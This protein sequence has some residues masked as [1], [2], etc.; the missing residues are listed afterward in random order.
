MIKLYK[1]AGSFNADE[2]R[3]FREDGKEL[4]GITGMLKQMLFKD[5]YKGVS[6]EVLQNAAERGHMIHSR[7]ELYDISGLGDDMP[8]VT[9]YARLR[10]MY[11]LEHI[12]SEYLVSDDENY[13][14]AIDKVYHQ[15][16]TPVDE[17]VL[18]D[19]KTTYNFNRDYVSWQLSVYAYFFEMMN[20]HLKVGRLIGIWIRNDKNRGLI[21]KIID[22]ERK[23]A[24]IVRELIRCAVEGREFTIERIPSF[25]SDNLDRLIWINDTISALS[26][27]KD[28]I[29]KDIL[30]KMQAKN[31]DKIDAGVVLFTKKAGST[32]TTF[33]SKAFKA[34]H[35]D[36]YEQYS[37]TSVGS[38]TLQVKFRDQ[39]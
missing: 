11:D 39:E 1:W 37:K 3:Y 19:I 18:G 5:E 16:D 31:I 23:P 15:K 21:N 8:E 35:E 34:E 29:V 10:K 7:I 17:V 2:H 14:S 33:D 36:L 26:E 4:Q 13:A 22:V 27:E 20:P 30:G 24:E 12:A 6:Q 32:R 25:I 38:E 9:A 28:N